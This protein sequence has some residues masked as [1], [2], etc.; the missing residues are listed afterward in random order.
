MVP[1]V[2]ECSRQ[3]ACSENSGLLSAS[4]QC[5]PTFPLWLA[6]MITGLGMVQRARAPGEKRGENV[7]VSLITSRGNNFAIKSKRSAPTQLFILQLERGG[8]MEGILQQKEGEGGGTDRKRKWL[9][10]D[11]RMQKGLGKSRNV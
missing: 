11:C 1:T 2:T 3:F 5:T 7:W 8:G 4:T 10:N 6:P 9:G